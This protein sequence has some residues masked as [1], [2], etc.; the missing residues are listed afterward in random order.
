MLQDY[1]SPQKSNFKDYTELRA[2]VNSTRGVAIVA[3]NMV[4][5]NQ[6]AIGGVSA[7]VYKGGTFGF[8]S[9]AEYT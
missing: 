4:S 8:A 1:L 9:G 2:H 6:S 3:G 5:N 7:R